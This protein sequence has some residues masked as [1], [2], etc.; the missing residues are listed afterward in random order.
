MTPR[1]SLYVYHII[2]SGAVQKHARAN[3]ALTM[4]IKPA[5]V[6][7]QPFFELLHRAIDTAISVGPAACRLYIET[8]FK[9]I[10]QSVEKTSWFF[11][12]LIWPDKGRSE[13]L[14]SE[15]STRSSA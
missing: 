14:P 12:T 5:L 1:I 2:N 9:C 3:S 11:S 4:A 10:A 15:F 13:N 8:R 7:A 6:T